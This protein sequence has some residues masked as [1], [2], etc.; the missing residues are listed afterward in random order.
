M[1]TETTGNAFQMRR[2]GERDV[3]AILALCEENR[4]FYQYHPPSGDE[5]AISADMTALRTGQASEYKVAVGFFEGKKLVAVLDW[6]SG[7]PAKETAWIGLFMVSAEKQGKGV[8][9]GII[10]DMAA[11][12]KAVGYREMQLG[13]DKG[14]PQSFAFWT[15]NGFEVLRED[16]YIVMRREI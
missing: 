3:D 9:S 14:N 5:G 12:L 10:R 6:I 8:G 11:S 2:L 1:R 16:G 7:Y 4:M 13:V 15:K